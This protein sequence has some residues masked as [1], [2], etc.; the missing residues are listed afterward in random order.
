MTNAQCVKINLYVL[1]DVLN[2]SLGI[3][4]SAVSIKDKVLNTDL[5]KDYVEV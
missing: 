3:G 4:R 5:G 1:E 2:A